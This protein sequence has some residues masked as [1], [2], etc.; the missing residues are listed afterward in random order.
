VEPG[1]A[2]P[3]GTFG[4]GPD[5]RLATGDGWLVLETVQLAGGRSMPGHALLLGRPALA[6]SRV[7]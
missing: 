3:A 6:G 1:P 2:G 7:R 5:L 4:P